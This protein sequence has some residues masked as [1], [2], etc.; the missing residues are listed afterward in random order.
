MEPPLGRP[1]F[2]SRAAVP[3]EGKVFG[4]RRSQTSAIRPSA[5]FRVTPRL[6]FP[7]DQYLIISRISRIGVGYPSRATA[8]IA[9]LNWSDVVTIVGEMRRRIGK[10]GFIT[11]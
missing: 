4:Q 10:I 11:A 8:I 9:R 2:A 5:L 1:L 7:P 3:K 6:R